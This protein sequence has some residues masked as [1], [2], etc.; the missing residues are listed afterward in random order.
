MFVFPAPRARPDP[1]PPQ[2]RARTFP[3][4]P[5]ERTPVSSGRITQE[6]ACKK[7]G[8]EGGGVTVGDG[9]YRLA[10]AVRMACA[11][12][13]GRV[14]HRS[15]L[16]PV[17]AH[18]GPPGTGPCILRQNPALSR[19]SPAQL[20]TV[21]GPDSDP[22]PTTAP[23]PGAG[24]SRSRPATAGPV[25]GSAAGG[26]VRDSEAER[27]GPAADVGAGVRVSGM[28]SQRRRRSRCCAEHGTGISAVTSPRSPGCR[29]AE[30][31]PA[32][33]LDGGRW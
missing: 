2:H 20:R 22:P 25:P 9:W 6:Q 8:W 16:A 12:P 18:S 30:R 1:Q 3:Q 4:R 21:S 29:A 19:T 14:T 5:A 33:D 13:N 31:A 28:L 27:V 26:R 7:A 15:D 17:H 11:I 23:V 10:R 32:Y 24:R